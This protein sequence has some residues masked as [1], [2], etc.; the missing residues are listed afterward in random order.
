[1]IGLLDEGQLRGTQFN[2][3]TLLRLGRKQHSDQG[4]YQVC[5]RRALAWLANV[6]SCSALCLLH[7]QWSVS[8]VAS[9]ASKSSEPIVQHLAPAPAPA[10][11][12]SNYQG[13]QE[14]VRWATEPLT[15]LRNSAAHSSSAL[16]S[17]CLW[18]TGT[19]SRGLQQTRSPIP[20]QHRQKRELVSWQIGGRWGCSKDCLR[21]RC[22]LAFCLRLRPRPQGQQ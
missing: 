6:Q 21:R 22:F 20:E 19:L 13:R 17:V 5:H 14:A 11:A 3:L 4:K 8:H 12:T 16:P 18:N 7:Q 2:S 15:Q 1:M 9:A 10:P